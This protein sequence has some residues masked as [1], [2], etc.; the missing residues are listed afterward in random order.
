MQFLLGEEEGEEDRRGLVGQESSGGSPASYGSVSGLPGGGG[1]GAVSLLWGGD[2]REEE[3]VNVYER[4]V[5]LTHSSASLFYFF[6][7]LS[8][9]PDLSHLP[10]E[11]ALEVLSKLNATDLCLAECVW[12]QLASDEILWQG[13]CKDQWPG[14]SVYSLRRSHEPRLRGV[15]YKRIYMRLDEGTLTFNSDPARGM[16]YFFENGL[17]VDKPELVA[18]FLLSTRSLSRVGKNIGLACLGSFSQLEN[19][20]SCSRVRFVDT[21]SSV[22]TS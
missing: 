11:L 18:S 6:Q 20:S 9:F 19:I 14:A 4:R 8:P 16:A 12:Q 17:L 10:P 15:S 2:G 21:F 5:S 3:E 22:R 13:L 7:P 1:G